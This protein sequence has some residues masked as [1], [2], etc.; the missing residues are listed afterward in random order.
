MPHNKSAALRLASRITEAAEKLG[1]FPN[2]G[3]EIG[4]SMR[5]LSLIYP[6]LIRYRVESTE[7]VIIAIRHGARDG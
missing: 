4:D 7:V 3:R 6:Y 5:Q 1:D 2:R